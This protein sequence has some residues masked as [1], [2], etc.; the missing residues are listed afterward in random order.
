MKRAVLGYQA[1]ILTLN[2]SLDIV[3]MQV[4]ES[5]DSRIEKSSKPTMGELPR[6]NEQGD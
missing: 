2:Q 4:E 1:G 6:T 3:G 5:G